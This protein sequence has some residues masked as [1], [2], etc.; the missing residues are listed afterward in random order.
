MSTDQL[1]RYV[2]I[3]EDSFDH[4]GENTPTIT[5]GGTIDPE[6]WYL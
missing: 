5:Y 6:G 2:E 4:L 1:D 3:L